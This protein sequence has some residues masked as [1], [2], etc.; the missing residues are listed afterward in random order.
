MAVQQKTVREVRSMLNHMI[1]FIST[2]VFMEWAAWALHKYV[3][4]GFLWVLHRDHHQ[5]KRGQVFQLNDA[6]AV[7]FAVPSFLLILCGTYF[8]NPIYATVGYG[9]MVYGIAYFFVH[10]VLIHRRLRFNLPDSTYLQALRAAHH[11]HHAV[12]EKE[13]CCNFGMLVVPLVYFRQ[14]LKKGR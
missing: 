8:W 4:H 13:G 2:F 7:F 6:F 5:P 3:M 11:D 14:Q 12:T 1:A 9:I 10:E